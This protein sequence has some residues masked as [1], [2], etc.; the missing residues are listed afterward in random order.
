MSARFVLNLIALFGWGVASLV[1]FVLVVLVGFIGIGLI[2]VILSFVATSFE[3]DSD[4]A[5]GD[6]YSSGLIG[7]QF[8]ARENMT[9]EQRQAHR[10][11]QSLA[12]KSARFF[13]HL[14]LGLAVI[15]FGGFIYS[16]M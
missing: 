12:T 11:E 2:G 5:A 16:H 3:L 14:G 7:S 8:R 13:K 15:G 4:M 6:G 1:A 10:S 9:P